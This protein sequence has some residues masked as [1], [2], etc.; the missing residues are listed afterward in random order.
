MLAPPPLLT[1]GS[2]GR[3][4]LGGKSGSVSDLSKAWLSPVILSLIC[5]LSGRANRGQ[6]ENICTHPYSFIKENFAF[7]GLSISS[8]AELA[9]RTSHLL[10]GFNI[11]LF[12]YNPTFLIIF[13]EREKE[14]IVALFP[15]NENQVSDN[16]FKCL[17]TSR[18]KKWAL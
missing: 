15:L 8:R 3:T 2:M 18:K 10:L 7:I 11:L 12:Y 1:L 16:C 17:M 13:D 4:D 14:N 5:I 6:Q 9:Q